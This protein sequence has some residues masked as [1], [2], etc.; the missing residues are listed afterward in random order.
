[1]RSRP[2][3]GSCQSHRLRVRFLL[4]CTSCAVWG[5][6][7]GLCRR[8]DAL[9]GGPQGLEGSWRD[10]PVAMTSACRVAGAQIHTTLTSTCV[11]VVRSSATATIRAGRSLMI[12]V[13]GATGNVGRHLVT[14][15]AAEGVPVRA[16]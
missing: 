3:R 2:H 10:P 12:L 1:M 4:S 13:T 9:F 15:L 8:M 5:P 14:R 16:L 11:E 6:V 7:S